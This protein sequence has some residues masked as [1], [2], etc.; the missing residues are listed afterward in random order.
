MT[1]AVL[2]NRSGVSRFTIQSMEQGRFVPS[3]QNL[4]KVA[5]ALRTVFVFEEMGVEMVVAE[6][7]AF[8]EKLI[9]TLS[10]LRGRR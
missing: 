3:V 1:Q 9:E 6:A 5:A 2:A 7:G 8:R 10:A 4:L